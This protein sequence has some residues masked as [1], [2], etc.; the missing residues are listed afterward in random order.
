MRLWQ[1][2]SCGRRPG[3]SRRSFRQK[4]PPRLLVEILED[5][6][7]PSIVFNNAAT[8]TTS[9][10]GGP[11]INEAHIELVFWGSGWNTGSGPSLRTSMQSA[12]DSIAQGPYLAALSVY[13]STI[14]SGSVADSITIT[15]SNPPNPMTDNDVRNVLTTNINNGTLSNPDSDSQTIYLVIPQP[16]TSAGSLGGTHSFFSRGAGHNNAHYVW[17]RNISSLDDIT[18]FASHELA[19]TVTDPEGTAIQVNPRSSTNWNEIGDGQAQN[20]SYRLNGYLVQSLF[21]NSDHAYLVPTGQTQDFLVSSSRVLTVNGDQLA[22]PND[23]ITLDTSGNGVTV[24]LNGE[25]AQFDQFDFFTHAASVSAITVNSGTGSDA[26]NV[27]RTLITTPVTVHSLGSATVTLGNSGSVQS[28]Q[29]TVTID[30]PSVFSAVV[31][32]DSADSGNRSVQL[33]TTVLSGANYGR[34]ISLAPAQILFKNS[35]IGSVLIATGTATETVNVL[36]TGVLGDGTGAITVEG[37]SANTTVN[38]GSGNTLNNILGDLTITN[39]AS[40]NRVNVNDAADSASHA[41]VVLT[42]TS[43]TGLSGGA[44][45]FGPNDLGALAINGGSGDNTYTI[46]DTPNSAFPAGLV[47]TLNTGAGA[48]SVNIQGTTG[49]LTVNSANGSG[50]DVITLSDLATTLS[51]IAGNITLIAAA[52]DSL[53][54]DDQGFSSTRAFAATDR[55]IAWGGPAVSYA[56]LGSVTIN[57]GSGGNTFAVLA[58]SASAAVAINGNGSVDTLV[59]SNAGNTFVITGGDTGALSGSAYNSAVSFFQVGNLTA[60]AGGDVF[61]FAD[62]ASLSGS[63]TGG[64]ADI[65]DYSACSTSVVVD[66]QTGQATGVGGSV[67]GIATVYGGNG[68]GELGAYNL[69][70]GNGGATL[71]GGTGR[72]NLLVAGASPGTL[73]GGDQ[74]D[75]LIAGSTS[76][77]TEAGLTSWLSIAAYWA[78]TDDFATRAANVTAGTGV[79]LL[80]ASVVSGN[81]GG[82]TLI[83]NGELALIYSDGLDNFL[84]AGFDP[85][86][87]QVLTAP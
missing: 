28:I 29:G 83:G 11:V 82:N 54:L 63:L 61:Q 41:N 7:V 26:V 46:A 52:T 13:R 3:A 33:D 32:D 55:T 58:T 43:L 81:S 65:L 49:A 10:G 57:G 21:Y 70:I 1:W 67:S 79:P 73:T 42:A 69:L 56:G 8:A 44:I 37:H 51:S 14:G 75:L 25:V 60:G 59:G 62:G 12:V 77:D 6:T 71:T 31:V 45:D 5:R 72:R 66:L 76:Y 2:L 80:D 17:T 9:D 68:N 34:I 48:D 86:A 47:T 35:D 53:V 87:Q 40:Y 27:L 30:N 74:E 78:S 39:P 19:E 16:G 20:Y 36:A 22:D 50:A 15:S 18:Y 84:G 24:T 38:V 23:T 4:A 64:G 85:N